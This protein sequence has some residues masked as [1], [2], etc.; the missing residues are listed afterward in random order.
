MCLLI[1]FS[2]SIYDYRLQYSIR[3]STCVQVHFFD[4]Y[5]SFEPFARSFAYLLSVF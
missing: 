2:V 5:D 3:L 4:F 1:C